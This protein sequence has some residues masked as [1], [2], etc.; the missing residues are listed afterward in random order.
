MNLET[1]KSKLTA[2]QIGEA[3][4]IGRDWG[5]LEADL[6]RDQHSESAMILIDN[7]EAEESDELPHHPEW[8]MGTY[9]GRIDIAD[10]EVRD[11]YEYVIDCAARD[12]WN[13]YIIE[14]NQ[15]AHDE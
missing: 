2:E 1:A 5:F 8:Q 13:E 3:V 14:E 15:L 10:S 11:A 6:W 9:A 7:F 12:A 4:A